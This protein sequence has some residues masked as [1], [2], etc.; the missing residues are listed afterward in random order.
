MLKLLLSAALL[1]ASSVQAYI[2]PLDLNL[3]EPQVIAVQ[4]APPDADQVTQC[5]ATHSDGSTRQWW[6]KLQDGKL[7]RY[8]KH[9]STGAKPVPFGP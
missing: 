4:C 3:P 9:P 6:L 8:P 1:A 5:T 7:H 2:E